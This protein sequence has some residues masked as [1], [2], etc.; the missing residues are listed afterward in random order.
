MGIT[1]KRQSNS[2]AVGVDGTTVGGSKNFLPKHFTDKNIALL[3][4]LCHAS[5]RQRKLILET[6]TKH[7]YVAFANVLLTH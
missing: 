6:L 4:A 1:R 2:V 7:S 5:Q 3:H